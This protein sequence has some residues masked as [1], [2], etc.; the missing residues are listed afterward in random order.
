MACLYLPFLALVP[1]IPGWFLK[2]CFC[3]SMT[4][5]IHHSLFVTAGICCVCTNVAGRQCSVH[6]ICKR[7]CPNVVYRGH[8]GLPTVTESDEERTLEGN[9]PIMRQI[10]KKR[11]E[12]GANTRWIYSCYQRLLTDEIS[13]LI[14]S[15]VKTQKLTLSRL[16]TW[17][18]MQPNLRSLCQEQDVEVVLK[19]FY[20]PWYNTIWLSKL[21]ERLE[22][23]LGV[24]LAIKQSLY[25]FNS[26]IDRYFSKRAFVK[27]IGANG[28]SIAMISVDLEWQ[29]YPAHDLYLIYDRAVRALERVSNRNFA[30]LFCTVLKEYVI[31]HKI[32]SAIIMFKEAVTE[33]IKRNHT[34]SVLVI[35]MEFKIVIPDLKEGCSCS[36]LEA[37]VKSEPATLAGCYKPFNSY[38]GQSL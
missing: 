15:L 5:T 3:I 23:H 17:I 16:K 24:N 19:S 25:E 7:R 14:C 34:T 9:Q 6:D 35:G 32:N 31:E 33:D 29:N 21:I 28:E 37:C 1:L 10:N 36:Q 11:A 22:Q 27:G 4:I 30:I 2:K 12:R 13:P 18:A 8:N 26:S 20:P 38:Y